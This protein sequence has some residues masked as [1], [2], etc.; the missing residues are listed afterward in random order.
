L[1]TMP[2]NVLLNDETALLGSARNA[3]RMLER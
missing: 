3:L 2:I 1:E